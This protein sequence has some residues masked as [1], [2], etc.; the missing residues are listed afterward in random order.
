MLRVGV[1]YCGGCNPAY[2][3]TALVDRMKERLRGKVEFVPV[4]SQ[5]VHVILAVHGCETACADLRGVG[6]VKIWP[7][8]NREEGEEFARETVGGEVHKGVEVEK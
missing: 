2:D 3:R 7:I 4:G 8:T 6:E 5:D 1:K